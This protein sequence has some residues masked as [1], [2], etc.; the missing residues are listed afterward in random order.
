MTIRVALIDDHPM[1]IGGLTAALET[2]PDLV[3]AGHAATVGEARPLLVSDDVDVI[4]LDVRLQDG[5]GIQLLVD[6]GLRRHPAVLV[7]SS[8]EAS[9]YPAAAA[10]YGAAGFLLKTVPLAALVDAIRSAAAGRSVFTHEQLAQR[11]VSLTGRER[12]VLAL[13]MEGLSNKEIG[14]RLGTSRKTV[15]GH[16]SDIFEKHDIHGGRIEL[17]L[18]ASEEGWLDVASVPNRR[19]SE[20]R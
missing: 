2:V 11:I 18:R 7:I 9:Q 4:L 12:E 13:A 3:I 6:R 10:K 19:S 14:A 5:N 8:F 1:V 15:E 17:S 16:L 20:C